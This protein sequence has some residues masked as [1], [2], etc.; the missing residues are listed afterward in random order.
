[1][2]LGRLLTGLSA[3]ACAT[4]FL[5]LRDLIFMT[6]AVDRPARG[7]ERPADAALSPS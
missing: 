1:M 7:S 5:P 4:A 3:I 2:T 6:C